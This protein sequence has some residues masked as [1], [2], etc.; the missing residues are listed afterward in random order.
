MGSVPHTPA[1]TGVAFTAEST[2]AAISS[3]IWFALPYGII[4]ANEPCPAI[5]NRPEL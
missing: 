4:P 2:S 5:R 1:S 3:T